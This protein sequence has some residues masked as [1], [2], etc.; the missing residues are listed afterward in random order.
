MEKDFSAL[1]FRSGATTSAEEAA[2]ALATKVKCPRCSAWTDAGGWCA[3]CARAV[4]AELKAQDR[5]Y[6]KLLREWIK[7]EPSH[8]EGAR[9]QVA[10][11][12]A[13]WGAFDNGGRITGPVFA[14]GFDH[15]AF[16]RWRRDSGRLR[17]AGAARRHDPV[18]DGV[19]VHGAPE[20]GRTAA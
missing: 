17:G 9:A 2:T 10:L 15:V 16:Y 4:I 6:V 20:N 3:P 8:A 18:L 1:S 13:E 14:P 19:G 11:L 7:A 5:E 12:A